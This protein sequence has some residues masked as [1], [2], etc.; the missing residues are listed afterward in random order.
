MKICFYCKGA[1]RRRRIEHAHQW[2]GRHLLINVA[3]EVCER[4]REVFL[5][6]ATLRGIDRRTGQ[7]S[8]GGRGRTR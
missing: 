7:P 4:C 6:P 1:L 2:G 3:A 5:S 8:P